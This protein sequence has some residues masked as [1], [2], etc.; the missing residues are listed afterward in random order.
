MILLIV[1]V[2]GITEVWTLF[3]R[4][5]HIQFGDILDKKADKKKIEHDK[6]Q[7]TLKDLV[8]DSHE[9]KV[10]KI[11]EA[12]TKPEE[13]PTSDITVN[14]EKGF[15]DIVKKNKDSVVSIAVVQLIEN[16]QPDINDVFR[17]SPFNDF[18][19]DFF[20]FPHK[21]SKPK[22]VQA[23]GSGFIVKI[24]KE[25][26]YIATN[27]HVVE[28][29]KK[30]IITL[31]DKTE[32]PAE[33]HA[34]DPRT[35]IAVI[36]V[37]LN[38]SSIGRKKLKPVTWGDSDDIAEGNFVVAIGSPFGFGNTVTNGIISSKGRNVALSKPSLSLID[39]FIQHST[40]IKMGSSGG[41]LLDIHGKVIGINNAIIT[42]NGGN[43]GIG[44]AIP[45]NIAKITIDQLIQHKRTFR[46]WIGI[47]VQKVGLNLA[48]SV[49]LAG[50]CTDQSQV[51]GAHV[52]KVI[53][54][55]PADKA[56]IV[57][58]DIIIAFNDCKVSKD[59][60][61]QS[62]VAG[63]PIGKSAK[64]KV[65]R[66]KDKG[67]W[68]TVELT[69]KVGDFEQAM[70]NGSLDATDAPEQ[71]GK[72][73]KTTADIPSL[74]ITVANI[75]DRYKNE[76]QPGA[77]VIV[78][79]TEE[80]FELSWFEPLFLPGDVIISANNILINSASQFAQIIQSLVDIGEKSPIPFVIIRNNS[81][82]MV[83]APVTLPAGNEKEKEKGKAKN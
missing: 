7:N 56:G 66:H 18:F 61:L 27:H 82:M 57:A 23:L 37:N 46:G 69:V 41:C 9:S 39:D 67:K 54:G 3:K 13:K 20:D 29:A 42:P 63:A 36:S 6:T 14:L 65:W 83:A 58:G 52:A 11:E 80:T 1:F 22:K 31:A 5:Y 47:E 73:Q 55:G 74:G 51:F 64:V 62:S 77:K 2:V 19:R 35:D 38:V 71:N 76:Y 45:S 32:L 12:P 79:K 81:R 59:K 49:G 78:T 70:Q 34:S 53:P 15:E 33:I 48:K 4:E 21:K 50:E 8:P 75:P 28:K 26:M 30:I 40:P 24:N 68:E 44:F 10:E 72:D 43:I 25:K 16:E 60:G 17:G